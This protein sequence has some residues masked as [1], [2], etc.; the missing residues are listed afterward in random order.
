M[1]AY[2][3]SV[4]IATI[5]YGHTGGVVLGQSI[6][7]ETAEHFLE[8]DLLF[9]SHQV[10]MCVTHPINQ[11]QYDALCC[12]VYNVG[13]GNFRKSTL[14]TYLNAGRVNDAE[15]EFLR[16]NKAGGKELKGLTSR[17]QAERELFNK[18]GV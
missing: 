3:D 16:W 9:A 12:F 11:H 13:G 8:S 7:V 10:D 17:R 18:Q 14:L 6:T 15:A 1:V 4:G 5:G 2:Q